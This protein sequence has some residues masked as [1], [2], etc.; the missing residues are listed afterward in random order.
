MILAGVTDVK[1]LK[2]K[3]RPEENHKENSPWNIATDFTID[4]SLSED[5]IKGML[6]EYEADHQSGMD[7]AV[8]AK[9]IREYTNGYPFLV[10]RICQLIDERVSKTMPLSDA[11]T[12]RGIDEADSR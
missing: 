11:W 9:S 7:T 1:H 12:G 6:D 4:M 3:I 8:I 10:S 2:N 5:G